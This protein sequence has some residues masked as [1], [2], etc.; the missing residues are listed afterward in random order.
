MSIRCVPSWPCLV[1]QCPLLTGDAG[2]H[3]RTPLYNNL[4]PSL[5]HPTPPLFV[6]V[7][8]SHSLFSLPAP[9][10]AC[11]LFLCALHCSDTHFLS[12]SCLSL[13]D[14][15]LSLLLFH[16]PL[17]L[18]PPSPSAFLWLKFCVTLRDETGFQ[19]L[20]CVPGCVRSYQLCLSGGGH[21]DWPLVHYRCLQAGTQLY[22]ISELSHR[23]ME[24]LQL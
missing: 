17:S 11:S 4:A 23:T 12:L 13:T 18:C 8:L 10:S 3:Q 2:H 16:F 21:R 24:N 6:S 1:E 19:H 22:F 20:V 7:F 5:S 14:V 9:S 15:S